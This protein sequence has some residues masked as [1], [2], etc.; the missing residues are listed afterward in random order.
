ME[1]FSGFMAVASIFGFLLTVVWL[2]LPF[3]VMAIKVKVDRSYLL[4]EEIER[5]LGA[6]ERRSGSVREESAAHEEPSRRSLPP[7]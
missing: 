1:I 2:I 4:L 7:E 6:M 5:R 3:V